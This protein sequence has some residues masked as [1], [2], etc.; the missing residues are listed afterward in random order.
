ME[1]REKEQLKALQGLLDG[2]S[3]GS[4]LEKRR[5][6][7]CHGLTVCTLSIWTPFFIRGAG[8]SATI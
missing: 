3:R 6:Y 7:E 5:C 8:W 4:F 1:G 2:V